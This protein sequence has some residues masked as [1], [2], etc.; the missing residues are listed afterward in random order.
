[1]LSKIVIFSQNITDKQLPLRDSLKAK[2]KAD[3]IHIYRFQKFRPYVNLD[4]R[5]SFVRSAP[6][7]VNG[8]QLGVLINEKHAVGIGRYTITATSQQKVRTKTDNITVDRELDMSYL[9]IFYQCELIDKRFFEFDMQ[10]E[11]GVGKYDLKFYNINTNKLIAD[12]SA[13]LLVEGLGPQATLKPFQWIGVTFMVG[14][15]FTFEKNANLN[16]NGAYYS[17]GVWLDIRQ[18]IRDCNYYFIKKPKY[19]KLLNQSMATDQLK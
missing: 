17:Y 13:G 5:N 2:L 3:S 18:I 1:M 11:S 19:R 6:I 4:Q 16:F 8:F 12:R 9:T 14:Y 10:V 15:R 7:N